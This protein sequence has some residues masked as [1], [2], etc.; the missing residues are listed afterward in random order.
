MPSAM[1]VNSSSWPAKSASIAFQRFVRNA[2]RGGKTKGS[3]EHRL[4]CDF[5]HLCDVALVGILQIDRPIAHDEHANRSVRQQGADVDIAWLTFKRGQVLAERFPFPLEA[6]VHDGAG[7]VL[8]AFHQFDQPLPIFGFARSEADA[9]I[10]HDT[11]VTPCHAL[12][13]KWSSHTAWAS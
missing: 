8:D 7:N 2:A 6:L 4:A 11:V 9:A 3:G 5:P 10:A 1:P 13:A 12:G